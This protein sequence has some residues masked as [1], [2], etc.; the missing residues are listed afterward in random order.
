MINFTYMGQRRYMWSGITNVR[1]VFVQK[2]FEPMVTCMM[3]FKEDVL[4]IFT[5]LYVFM[6]IS[7]IFLTSLETDLDLAGHPIR[8]IS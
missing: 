4:P 6:K 5:S 7:I 2:S 1:Q 8:A 3:R